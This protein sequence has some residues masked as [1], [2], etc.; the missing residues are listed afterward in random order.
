VNAYI[1]QAPID[2]VEMNRRNSLGIEKVLGIQLTAVG[3]D[4]VCGEMPVDERTRQPFGILHGGASVVLAETLGSFASYLA[5]CDDP[6]ARVAGIEVGASHVRSVRSGVVR[7]I[8]RPIRLGRSL[9]FWRIDILAPDGGLSCS[10]R[11]TVKV[12]T[13]GD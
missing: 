8:A 4:F 10:A 3:P 5:V 1:S 9:H 11:L 12:S 2:L 6:K 7:G 13:R